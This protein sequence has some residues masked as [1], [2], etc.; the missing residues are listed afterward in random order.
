[1]HG[2]MALAPTAFTSDAATRLCGEQAP[3]DLREVVPPILARAVLGPARPRHDQLMRPCGAGDDPAFGIDQHA[4]RFEG[5]D[6]DA[7]EI[8]HLSHDPKKWFPLFG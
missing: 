7:E 3:A 1:M 2:P 5:A 6:V 4:L 8:A